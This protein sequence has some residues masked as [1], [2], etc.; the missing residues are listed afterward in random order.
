MTETEKNTTLIRHL[1]L[2][3]GG[4]LLATDFFFLAISLIYQMP[5]MRNVVIIKM[6]INTTNLFLILKKHYFISTVIIYSVI[7]GFMIVGVICV[8]TSVEFQ[9]FS[10]G[11]LGCISYLGY[12][13][14]RVLKKE[15]PL[16]LII[17]IHVLGYIAVFVYTKL[18][19]PLYVLP[20]SGRDI[21]LFF[22]SFATFSIVILFVLLFHDVAIQSEEKLEKMA[23]IDNLTGL[24]NRHYLLASLDQ[25]EAK[26][27]A[28]HWIAI[29]DIDDFKK[30]NDTYGHN[31]GDYVLHQVAELA[32]QTCKNCIVCRWGGEEF[33]VFSPERGCSTDILETLRKRIADEDFRFEDTHLH[34][35]VT[36]GAAYYDSSLTNDGWISRAD[37]KLY[38]GKTSGKNRVVL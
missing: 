30:V 16:V 22:N 15:L 32:K 26:D 6:I 19:D 9:S 23:M 33:I 7:L 27:P 38:S 34:I 35:T 14:K 3:F 29:L 31:C 28:H 37:E 12:L 21:L 17:A 2:F 5:V 11:M 36:I 24:Y 10:L 20:E 13:H 18:Q 1:T 8:G 25:M 4:F